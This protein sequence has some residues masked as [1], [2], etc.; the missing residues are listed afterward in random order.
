MTRREMREHCFKILFGV[1]F[2]PTEEIK[3]QVEQYFDAP[4]EDDIA[5]NGTEEVVHN[6]EMKEVD[7]TFLTD[8]V[9]GIAG[10]IPELDARIDEV[11]QG[12]AFQ[13]CHQRGGKPCEEIWRKGFTGFHQRCAGEACDR[14]VIWPAFILFPR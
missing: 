7:R 12:C 6:V 4:Q 10:K 11:A 3:A 14:G 1:E 9:E 5:E 13:G 8:R 2:Y